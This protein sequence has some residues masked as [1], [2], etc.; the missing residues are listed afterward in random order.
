MNRTKLGNFNI[1]TV[2]GKEICFSK[3][4]PAID[5]NGKMR[6]TTN[7]IS[8]IIIALSEITKYQ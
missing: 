8:A 4:K 3:L 2:L 6:M 5:R 7:K 1:P